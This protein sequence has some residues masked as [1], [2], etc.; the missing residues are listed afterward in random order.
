MIW[1]WT[2]NFILLCE[3]AL[4]FEGFSSKKNHPK[5]FLGR[6]LF[7]ACTLVYWYDTSMFVRNV[8]RQSCGIEVFL[9]LGK[10]CEIRDV[11]TKK[12]FNPFLFILI[13]KPWR[14]NPFVSSNKTHQK[15]RKKI[16]TSKRRVFFCWFV[17]SQKK[18]D[19]STWVNMAQHWSVNN[20]KQEGPGPQTSAEI[21]GLN[22]GTLGQLPIHVSPQKA[23][24]N[25]LGAG[26]MMASDPTSSLVTLKFVA[27]NPGRPHLRGRGWWWWCSIVV[28]I[29]L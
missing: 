29:M 28:G 4:L 25:L 12:R 27:T 3:M 6:K 17:S 21:W 1:V 2:K 14:W 18:N 26:P 16:F 23:K 19:R 20:H 13:L 9:T 22:D 5:D 24:S 7:H 10:W 11:G 8:A 15:L